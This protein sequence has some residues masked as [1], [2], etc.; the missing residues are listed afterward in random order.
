EGRM[1]ASFQ[2]LYPEVTVQSAPCI[3]T[4]DDV[5]ILAWH[6]PDMITEKRVA[7]MIDLA[8]VME[9]D[10]GKGVKV[11][12]ENI[13][14][15]ARYFKHPEDCAV[16]APGRVQLSPA[17]RQTG[18]PISTHRVFVGSK[19]NSARGRTWLSSS[20]ET[21]ALITTEMRVMHPP[22]YR[23][24][25]S[26]LRKLSKTYANRPVGEF[27]RHWALIFT[28]MDIITNRQT[29][30][31]RD[32]NAPSSS[33]DLLIT[34]LG[35]P[36]TTLDLPTLNLRFSYRSGTGVA[37]AGKFLPHSVLPAVADRICYTSYIREEA[38]QENDLS[39]GWMTT[40]EHGRP[41]GWAIDKDP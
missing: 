7:V 26:L 35:D 40:E 33:H 27:L 1:S 11:G 31:H 38:L 39:V 10:I 36:Q 14:D 41:R 6:V 18:H 12:S 28:G 20:L 5:T 30:V 4:D 32:S 21:L 3:L 2:P 15:G 17:S 37:I 24:A 34:L 13:Q 8:K 25:T 9:P 23:A 19:L 22:Q 16:I 29:V